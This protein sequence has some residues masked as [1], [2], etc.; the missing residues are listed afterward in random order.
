[1]QQINNIRPEVLSAQQIARGESETSYKTFGDEEITSESQVNS[2]T[3]QTSK[4]Q[5]EEEVVRRALS[6]RAQSASEVLSAKVQD[7]TSRITKPQN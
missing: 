5:T 2:R 3:E 7:K 1:M 6:A 4:S